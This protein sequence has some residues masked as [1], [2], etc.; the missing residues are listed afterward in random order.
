M[1]KLIFLTIYLTLL[2]T[3]SLSVRGQ[4][5]CPT[6]KVCISPAAA[7]Q[8]LVDSDTV[9]AQKIEL[10]AKEKAI[11]DMRDE[12]NKMRIEFARTSGELTA[13]K[14]NAVSDRAIIELLL[15]SA[16][17]KCFPFSLCL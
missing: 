12:L 7:R 2:L 15:K 1:K 17:K 4:E 9:A 14:Q 8:A 3:I 11:A 13:T 10:E 5:A 16:K 6:D